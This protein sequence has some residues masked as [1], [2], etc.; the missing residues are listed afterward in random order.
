MVKQDGIPIKIKWNI[1]A[2]PSYNVYQVLKVLLIKNF[3]IQPQVLLFPF[4]L[5]ISFYIIFCKFIQT[6]K[7]ILNCY[8]QL[9]A[10]RMKINLWIMKYD[11][12]ASQLMFVTKLKLLKLMVTASA[13]EYQCYWVPPNETFDL[14]F[15]CFL[16]C[17]MRIRLCT[18]SAMGY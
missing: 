18:I 10:R 9:K 14:K 7:S 11:V 6:I 2:L 4:F 3:K 12:V 17:D 13:W 16:N 5:Y 8:Q 1:H 15:S